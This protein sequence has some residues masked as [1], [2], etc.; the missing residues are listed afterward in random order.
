MEQAPIDKEFE[1]TAGANP[2]NKKENFAA[3][4]KAISNYID[5]LGNDGKRNVM[6]N[7]YSNMDGPT[8]GKLIVNA[9]KE[10]SNLSLIYDKKFEDVQK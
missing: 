10:L 4:L 3:K 1:N 2:A 6:G 5:E 7:K 9:F 8:V